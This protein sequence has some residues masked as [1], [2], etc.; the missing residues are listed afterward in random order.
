LLDGPF[1]SYAPERLAVV[2]GPP[3]GSFASVRAYDAAGRRLEAY[4]GRSA[5]EVKDGVGR[6]SLAFWGTVATLEID[7]VEEWAEVEIPFDLPAAPKRPAGKEG[8]APED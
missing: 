6:R 8:L 2:E 7:S 5:W 4:T 1:V 3:F